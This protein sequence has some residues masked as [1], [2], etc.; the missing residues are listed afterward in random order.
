MGGK[1]SKGTRKDKRLKENKRRTTGLTGKPVRGR[2]PFGQGDTGD[3][4]F[5]I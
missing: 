1:P 5:P 2:K 3:G 4:R